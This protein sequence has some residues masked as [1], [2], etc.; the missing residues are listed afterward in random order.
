[1]PRIFSYKSQYDKK[2]SSSKEYYGDKGE[3]LPSTRGELAS[4]RVY[5]DRDYIEKETRELFTE[6]T[7]FA[8]GWKDIE[9]NGEK[10]NAPLHPSGRYAT[11]LSFSIRGDRNGA[12]IVSFMASAEA[13]EAFAIEK[14][15]KEVDLKKTML[16]GK[17]SMRIPL[18][19]GFEGM[20]SL[21]ETNARA[22]GKSFS[23]SMRAIS[24][25]KHIGERGVIAI[26]T[27]SANSDKWIMQEWPHKRKEDDQM[28][29]SKPAT[30]LLNELI[31]RTE[32]VRNG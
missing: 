32:E 14:G 16:G 15:R 13:P 27:M 22:Q 1:M 21:G 29:P 26:R 31:R 17:T 4:V 8:V 3:F 24:T 30:I 2:I 19:G 9:Y 11:S 12:Y 10:A 20:A 5:G 18:K 23:R 25:L 28:T 7:E 6:F